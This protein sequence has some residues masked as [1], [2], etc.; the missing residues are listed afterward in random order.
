[1]S[2]IVVVRRKSLSF[3]YAT[4]IEKKRFRGRIRISY[5]KKRATSF[6]QRHV[7]LPLNLFFSMTTTKHR[8]PYIIFVSYI[9]FDVF[10]VFS[11]LTECN[12]ILLN[13]NVWDFFM[14]Y[15]TSQPCRDPVYNIKRGLV[16]YPLGLLP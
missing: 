15:D 16:K 12:I 10:F 1:M 4:T 14:E 7:I 3:L 9:A 11:I 2:H 5:I 13:G 8:K 6:S